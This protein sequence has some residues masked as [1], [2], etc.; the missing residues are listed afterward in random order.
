MVASL[1]IPV[2][3]GAAG[4]AWLLSRRTPPCAF[5]GAPPPGATGEGPSSGTRTLF[6]LGERCVWSTPAGDV[7]TTTYDVGATVAVVGGLAVALAA[8]AVVAVVLARSSRT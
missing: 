3:L 2:A 7:A 4:I 5:P 6:P 1:L 8:A